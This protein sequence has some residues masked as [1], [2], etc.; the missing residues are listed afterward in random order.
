MNS[1]TADDPTNVEGGFCKLVVM[2]R[3]TFCNSTKSLIFKPGSHSRRT[4]KAAI[5]LFKETYHKAGT[6]GIM[7]SLL[8]EKP[9]APFCA[10]DSYPPFALFCAYYGAANEDRR[11]P[12]VARLR[13]G[14]NL[15]DIVQIPD[16][17][18]LFFVYVALCLHL[19][20]TELRS[21]YF[22]DEATTIVKHV[23]AWMEDEANNKEAQQEAATQMKDFLAPLKDTLDSIVDMDVGKSDNETS[24]SDSG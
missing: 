8:A 17:A 1:T 5:A 15:H 20:V 13:N 24:D 12:N 3:I 14:E 9:Q 4:E 21:W 2:S 11:W 19:T 7:E 22:S 16:I 18:F 10:D 23:S 6:L